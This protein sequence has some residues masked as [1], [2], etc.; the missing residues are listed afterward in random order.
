MGNRFYLS[1]VK[2]K[3]CLNE[4]FS[5]SGRAGVGNVRIL[6]K[7]TVNFLNGAYGGF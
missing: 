3:S 4:R 2:K 5:V 1:L 7:K 6:W